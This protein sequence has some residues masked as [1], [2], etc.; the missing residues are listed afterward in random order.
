LAGANPIVIH[1]VQHSMHPP[2]HLVGESGGDE[3]FL[4][5]I[6]RGLERKQPDALFANGRCLRT[7]VRRSASAMTLWSDYASV[8]KLALPPAAVVLIDV[9]TSSTSQLRQ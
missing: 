8:S 9:D 3:S 5:F 7:H 6:T 4:V 1:G 2:V